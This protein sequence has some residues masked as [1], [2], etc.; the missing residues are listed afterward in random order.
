MFDLD[1]EVRRWRERQE[2]KS[3]LSPRE[4]EE[5]EDHLRARVDLELEINAT[6][7][8]RRAFAIA[9]RELGQPTA[10]EKEFVKAGKPRWRR[11]L[12]AG[13]AMFAASFVLPVIPEFMAPGWVWGW[14][15]FVIVPAMAVSFP[16]EASWGLLSWITN[17][18]IVVTWLK[19]RGTRTRRAR[20]LA[21]A[22]TAATALNLWWAA[23]HMVDGYW[24]GLRDYHIGYWAWAASF[25]CIA[26]ALWMRDREWRSPAPGPVDSFAA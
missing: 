10:L 24:S 18:L 7:A 13:W 4:L 25:G 20:W 22:M 9:R 5:L 12:V 14:Q 19:V 6:L 23:G 8:P 17:A 3:S 11:W 15:V 26:A 21:P 1:T 2:R 16:L